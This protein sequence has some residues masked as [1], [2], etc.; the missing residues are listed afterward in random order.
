MTRAAPIASLD[1]RPQSLSD[2]PL[3]RRPRPAFFILRPIIYMLLVATRFK[4]DYPHTFDAISLSSSVGL[5]NYRHPLTPCPAK[6]R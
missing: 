6:R 2:F 5:S 3:H 1:Y 4:R